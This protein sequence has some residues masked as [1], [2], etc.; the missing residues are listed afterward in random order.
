[1]IKEYITIYS[2]GVGIVH[3]ATRDKM[4]LWTSDLFE[5]VHRCISYA[6]EVSPRLN[7]LIKSNIARAVFDAPGYLSGVTKD[8][9]IVQCLQEED[10]KKTSDAVCKTQRLDASTELAIFNWYTF[11]TSFNDPRPWVLVEAASRLPYKTESEM[12]HVPVSKIGC[13]H[14]L[15]EYYGRKYLSVPLEMQCEFAG[16]LNP[17]GVFPGKGIPAV[18]PDYIKM[19]LADYARRMYLTTESAYR[20]LIKGLCAGTEVSY[21]NAFTKLKELGL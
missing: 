20:L 12:C 4:E 15:A 18:S 11:Y 17:Y 6:L 16:K 14:V 21:L 8:A 2:G 5:T 7:E 3:D 13:H 9:E 10:F 19:Y 1:M